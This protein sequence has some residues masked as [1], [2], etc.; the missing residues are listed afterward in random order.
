[1]GKKKEKRLDWSRVMELVAQ[2]E[3]VRVIELGTM[4]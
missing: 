1:L 3:S 2:M 4:F